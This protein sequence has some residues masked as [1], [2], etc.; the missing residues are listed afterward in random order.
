MLSRGVVGE[1][2]EVGEVVEVRRL[3]ILVVQR[4]ARG[5]LWEAHGE[6]PLVARA[7]I[8]LRSGLSRGALS[9]LE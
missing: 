6:A 2:V 8:G 7:G 5:N 1:T 9:A 3:V 4:G